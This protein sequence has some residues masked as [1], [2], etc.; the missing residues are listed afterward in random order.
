MFE[1]DE[2]PEDNLED[3]LDLEYEAEMDLLKEL[4]E[5]ANEAAIRSQVQVQLLWVSRS[6][7]SWVSWNCTF[8]FGL[9]AMF[10]F[11]SRTRDV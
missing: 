3:L 8:A 10:F 4:E 5:E 11:H 1:P 2:I 7:N 6:R 9:L